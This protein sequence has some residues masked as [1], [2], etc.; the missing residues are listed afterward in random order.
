M[1][2][3][4]VVNASPVIALAKADALGLLERSCRELL[5]PEAVVAEILAGPPSDPRWKALARDGS[6]LLG[7]ESNSRRRVEQALAQSHRHLQGFMVGRRF[8]CPTLQVGD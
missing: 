5:V 2:D 7:V 3:V 6:R 1:S 4:W 8:A